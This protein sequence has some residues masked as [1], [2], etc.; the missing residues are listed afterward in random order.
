MNRGFVTVAKFED[1]LPR[2]AASCVGEAFVGSSGWRYLPYRRRLSFLYG[3]NRLS[4]VRYCS[5][6][7][8]AVPTVCLDR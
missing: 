1:E 2:V 4:R 8:R 3:L 5:N 6:S 7:G